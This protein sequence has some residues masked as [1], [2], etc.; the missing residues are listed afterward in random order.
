MLQKMQKNTKVTTLFL[1]ALYSLCNQYYILFY[2]NFADVNF[3]VCFFLVLEG[4]DFL[5]IMM[6]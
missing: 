1:N 2:L 6:P 4:L 3:V 5:L